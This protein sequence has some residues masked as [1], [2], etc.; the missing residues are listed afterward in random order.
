MDINARGVF[1]G[2]KYAIPAMLQSGGGSVI[3]I[4]STSGIVGFLVAR[5]ITP[6]RGSP[7]AHESHCGGVRQAGYSGQFH[8]S[9][10]D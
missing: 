5:P 1:L 3:N 6:P 4:S 7:P 9:W 8:A 2:M 10:P